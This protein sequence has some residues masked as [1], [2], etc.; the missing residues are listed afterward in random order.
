MSSCFGA[1]PARE[2]PLILPTSDQRSRIQAGRAFIVNNNVVGNAMLRG[3]LRLELQLF[4]EKV[5]SARQRSE[6]LQHRPGLLHDA[7]APAGKSVLCP[8]KGSG[9]IY[10]YIR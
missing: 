6:A 3:S 10:A 4:P 1:R 5:A 2:R 7:A 8:G 9:R